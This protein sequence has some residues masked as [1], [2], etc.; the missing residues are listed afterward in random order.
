[1]ATTVKTD[2]K[3]WDEKREQIK[4][5]ALPIFAAKGFKATT[6]RDIAKAANIAPGLIYWYFKSKEDLF[7]AILDESD[8]EQRLKLPLETMIDIPPNKLLPL[9]ARGLYLILRENTYLNIMRIVVAESMRSPES[10]ERF[11]RLFQ[12]VLEPLTG[13]FTAQINQGILREGDPRAMAVFFLNSM[14]TMVMWPDDAKHE[15]TEQHDLDVAA[16]IKF[17][18]SAFMYGFSGRIEALR[19]TALRTVNE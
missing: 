9:L 17:V 16:K 19:K 2:E 14:V 11:N 7:L 15:E 13:Y 4:E 3:R 5:A 1:M 12:D 8:I 6:N 10:Q 18:C